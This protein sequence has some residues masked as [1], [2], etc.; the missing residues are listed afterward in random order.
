M[1]YS[2]QNFVYNGFFVQLL[3]NKAKYTV[4]SL[5]NWTN[6]PG[7][8][9]FLCSDK[10]ERLIPTCCLSKDFLQ[11]QKTRPKLDPFK[12]KGVLFGQSAKS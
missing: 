10:K 9:L 1:D 6:D 12:G 8:G 11:T 7:I 5:I 4:D 3:Q 2:V